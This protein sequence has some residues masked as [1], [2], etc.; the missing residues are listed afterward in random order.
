MRA[1][2][3]S[4]RSNAHCSPLS[5]RLRMNE[6]GRVGAGL[7]VLDEPTPFLPKR[8]IDRLFQLVRGVIAKG[9][10]VIFVSHDVDQVMEITDRATVLRDGKVAAMIETSAATKADFIEAIVGR[11]LAA[12]TPPAHLATRGPSHAVVHNLSGGTIEG[13]SLDLA[14]GEVVGVTGLIG[15]GY[16]EIPYLFYGARGGRGGTLAI[17]GGGVGAR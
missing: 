4:R 17:W 11:K 6:A 15:S 10:G 2:P 16:D 13:F 3:T 7:L 5:A 8:D 9:A 1:S 12:V 14:A